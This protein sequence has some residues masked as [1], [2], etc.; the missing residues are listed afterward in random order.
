MISESQATIAFETKCNLE[1]FEIQ[2]SSDAIYLQVW[3]F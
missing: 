1:M 3:Y 2:K